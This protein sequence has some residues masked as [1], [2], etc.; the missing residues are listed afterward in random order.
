MWHFMTKKISLPCI[1]PIAR[2]I[3]LQHP[4]FYQTDSRCCLCLVPGKP[5]IEHLLID[6]KCLTAVC[7]KH[8]VP[9]HRIFLRNFLLR[10]SAVELH[11]LATDVFSILDVGGGGRA[12][13]NQIELF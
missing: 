6:C 13:R 5:T 2:F 8:G 9:T 10:R 11:A 3:G 4:Y 1:S 7:N 12:V